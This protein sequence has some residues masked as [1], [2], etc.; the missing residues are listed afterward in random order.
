VSSQRQNDTRPF[1]LGFLQKQRETELKSFSTAPTSLTNGP[2][3]LE[4][5]AE[6]L[7]DVFNKQRAEKIDTIE[8]K[9]SEEDA[10]RENCALLASKS[11]AIQ[12][13]SWV[14]LAIHGSIRL[15]QVGVKRALT[16]TLF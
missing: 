10:W 6:W 12:T 14:C 13:N 16:D 1:H 3:F 7:L 4:L 8:P 2:P 15:V 5:Q 9:Q 11:L